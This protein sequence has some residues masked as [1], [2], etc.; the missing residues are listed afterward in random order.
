MPTPSKRRFTD[1]QKQDVIQDYRYPRRGKSTAEANY[2][3]FLE[4]KKSSE[5]YYDPYAGKVTKQNIPLIEVYPELDLLLAGKAAVDAFAKPGIVLRKERYGRGRLSVD[6]KTKASIRNAGNVLKAKL[7]TDKIKDKVEEEGGKIVFGKSKKD[8]IKDEIENMVDNLSIKNYNDLYNAKNKFKEYLNSKDVND[9]LSRI[10]SELKTDYV[11]KSDLLFDNN[12]SV[13]NLVN[14]IDGSKVFG[15]TNFYR[16][17]KKVPADINRSY[18]RIKEGA[19]Y[20]TIGHEG[21]HML[22][23]IVSTGRYD[24]KFGNVNNRLI[25]LIKGKD[26][27][28]LVIKQKDIVDYYKNIG[29]SDKDINYIT[30]MNE[31][32]SFLGEYI[33]REFLKTGKIP[34]FTRESFEDM[35]YNNPIKNNYLSYTYKSFIRDKNTFIDNINKYAF[36]IS[37]LLMNKENNNDRSK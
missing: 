21:R 11:R 33:D 5:V 13:F 15:R 37:P 22:D 14:D 7:V 23:N 8:I 30:D 19:P 16:D 36:S 29:F 10:D 6:P 3:R 31:I 12:K 2:D 9:K 18:I 25:S 28:N 20:N 34:T 26:G 27:K 24:D 32:S 4:R 35:I 17:N 1:E